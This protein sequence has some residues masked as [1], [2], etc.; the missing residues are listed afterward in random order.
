[1]DEAGID[2]DGVGGQ[3][4]GVEVEDAHDVEIDP[5]EIIVARRQQRTHS[6]EHEQACAR[7]ELEDQGEIE[8]DEGRRE[9]GYASEEA[10]EIAAL[11]GGEGTG[12]CLDERGGI[13][14]GIARE[15]QGAQA[16]GLEAGL[17]H[18]LIEGAMD[19][20]QAADALEHEA[21]AQGN[22]LAAVAVMK[23]RSEKPR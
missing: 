3:G 15:E 17:E 1:M 21:E 19:A 4:A 20:D 18:I 9:P 23:M 22:G 6:A 8:L 12:E 5:D 16:I 14:D 13:A 10:D 7:A 2:E 11:A